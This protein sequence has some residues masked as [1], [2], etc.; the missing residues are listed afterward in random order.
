MP[1]VN[2]IERDLAALVVVDVQSKMLAAIGSDP[3][4]GVIDR[5]LQLIRTAQL[6]EL[7]IFLTEQYPQGL[8]H[9]DER[10]K[11][12]LSELDRVF[13]KTTMSCWRDAAFSD[14]LQKSGREHIIVCGV[15]SHVC[16]QQTVLDLL[17]VDYVPFV[18]VNAVA[19][20]FDFDK[21]AALERMRTAGAELT[22]SEALVF[23]LVER[24]DDPRF[25]DVLKLVK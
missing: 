21:V 25:K 15:E 10:V 4:A 7:P 8:G 3:V 6:F 5:C 14:A 17:R 11:S 24:C 18:P 22:T 13:E 23:E 19:S 12:A 9:T 16:I 20:R 2:M 1:H